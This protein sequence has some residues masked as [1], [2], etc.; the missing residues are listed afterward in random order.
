M[1]EVYFPDGRT[2]ELA[3]NVIAEGVYAQC[4]ADRNRC[5]LLDAIIDYHT[6]PSV[7]VS[8]NNQVS[9]INGKKIVKRTTRGWE[10]WCKW[11]DDSTSWQK[12]SDLK[13]SHPLQVDGFAFAMQIANEPAL[14]WCVSWVFKKRDWIISQVKCRSA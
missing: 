10:L 7:A 8:R 3:T 6:D 4:D 9:V 2:E 1:Y 11:K 14:N 13:E 12:L 5:V